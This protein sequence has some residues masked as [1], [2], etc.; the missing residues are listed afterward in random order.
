MKIGIVCDSSSDITFELAD[1]L[2]VEVVETP[3]YIDDEEIYLSKTS[4]SDFHNKIDNAINFPTTSQPSPKQLQLAYEKL[5]SNGCDTIIS[6]HLSSKLSGTLN[7][8][9][10]ASEMVDIEIHLVDTLLVSVP[11][12]AAIM[13]CREL[14][15]RELGINTIIEKLNEFCDNTTGYTSLDTLDN[16]VR[17]GRITR[18]RFFLGKLFNFKPILKIEDGLL[19]S[20]S[21]TRNIDKSREI[22]YNLATENIRVDKEYCYLISHANIPEIAKKYEKRL[23]EEYPNISGYILDM[24]SISVHA[25]RGCLIIHIFKLD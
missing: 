18:P 24:G 13:Y 21:K 19:R 25:G 20:Y 6:V 22:I 23:L 10:I 9:R 17:S 5:K 12:L 11:Y 3:I 2:N 8:A 14:V 15:N 1:K 4:M 7:S 16:L